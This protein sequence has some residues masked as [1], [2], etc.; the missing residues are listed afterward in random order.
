MMHR[1]RLIGALAGGAVLVVMFALGVGRGFASGEGP[2]HIPCATGDFT[3]T[4]DT[5]PGGG[6]AVRLDGWAQPCT[7]PP[8]DASDYRFTIHDYGTVSTPRWTNVFTS[9]DSPTEFS[10]PVAVLDT[11]NAVCLTYGP[12]GTRV[13]CVSVTRTA[14][15]GGWAIEPMAVDDS[16]VVV[17]QKVVDPKSQNTGTGNCGHCP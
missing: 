17:P 11:T 14:D 1:R 9:A 8:G 10:H 12:T 7:P 2:N 6:P 16:A 13:K 5:L 15:S 4:M 3:A